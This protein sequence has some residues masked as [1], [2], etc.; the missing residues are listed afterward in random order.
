MRWEVLFR[1][2]AVIVAAGQG[3]RMGRKTNK[4]YLNFMDKPVLAHTLEVFEKHP[5]IDG[6]IV[7]TREE[8]I[9][10]CNERVI[11][12]FKFNKIINVV[13]GG[14][15]RQDSVYQGLKA[16]PSQCELVVVHDGARPLLTLDLMTEV[17]NT[18]QRDKAAILAVPVKDTVKRVAQGLVIS[19]IPRAEVWAVQTPQ[20]FS[21]ELILKAY[22]HAYQQGFYG[23]DDASLVE[24]LGENVRIVHGSYENIKMTTPEDLIIGEAI[25]QR[26]HFQ[27]K[28]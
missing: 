28:F 17:I 10:L 3:K 8:E 20:V 6:V 13:P 24:M 22:E 14:K 15:E 25:L 26:R 7:V 23:T 4:Q 5:L 11:M 27:E 9:S 18:A 2:I 19:T 16:L 1:N 12:P 21:K